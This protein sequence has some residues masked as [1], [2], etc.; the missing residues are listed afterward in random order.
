M[1]RERPKATKSDPKNSIYHFFRTTLHPKDDHGRVEV[2]FLRLLC[3]SFMKN[4]KDIVPNKKVNADRL[5]LKWG[6]GPLTKADLITH[7]WDDF[8]ENKKRGVIR[9][10]NP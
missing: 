10:S 2:T 1:V 7:F 9:E 4:Y 3:T 5:V 6:G 8:F